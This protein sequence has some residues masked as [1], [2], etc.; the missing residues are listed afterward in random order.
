M[1]K[2]LAERECRACKRVATEGHHLLFL[3]QGGDDVT[4]NIIPLCY[5]C[6]EKVHSGDM[7]TRRV[8]ILTIQPEEREYL[9]SKFGDT[10]RAAAWA[11]RVYGLPE[12][13][14]I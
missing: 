1:T 10:D 6:H 12:G 3:S 11:E 7:D 4:A 8:I 14:W 5:V 2:L 13:M 9:V